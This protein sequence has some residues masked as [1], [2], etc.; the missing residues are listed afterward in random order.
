MSKAAEDKTDAGL[1]ACSRRRFLK[2]GALGVL[3]FAAARRVA[4]A[5]G[6]AG[7]RRLPAALDGASSVLG[8]AAVGPR[9]RV[10]LVRHPDVIDAG[11]K[12]QGPL[13]QSILDKAVTTFTGKS[14]LADAWRQFVALDD[15]VGLKLNTLGLQE[16]KGTDLTLHFSA[17]VEALAAGLKSAGV[18]DQNVVVWDR[19]EEE[20]TEA[21]LTIQKE[22]GRMRFMAN[23]GSR[24]GSGNYAPATY[25][26]GSRSSRVSAILADVCTALINVPVPKTHGRSLITCALKNH[27]GTIDNPSEFHANGCSDPG[28]PEVNA[29][30]IIRRKQKLIVSDALLIVPEGGARWTRRFIR[31]FGGV[32]VGTDPVAVDAV[33]L[34]IID[35][36]REK[37]GM[38][39]IGDRVVHLPLAEKLGLGNSRLENIDLV[40]LTLS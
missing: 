4:P 37:E 25:P 15:V 40:R 14:T 24:M 26:V 18:R 1:R 35:D 7:P 12:V 22:P 19:S 20:M 8:R 39:R 6:L 38:E 16:V 23:K 34:K 9:S 28:I 5:L 36:E 17:I 13:L 21:G 29:I 2:H 33:A 32:I 3:G 31:P 27:Y 11:G 30:P 10:V